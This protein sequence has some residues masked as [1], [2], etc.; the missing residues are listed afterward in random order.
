MAVCEKCGSELKQGAIICRNCG[1]RVSNPVNTGN[2]NNSKPPKSKEVN[3]E[4]TV[5]PESGMSV[6]AF[7][8]MELV[9]LVPCINIIMLIVWAVSKKNV[10]R[11]NYAKAKLLIAIIG[12]IIG[13]IVMVLMGASLFAS[14]GNSINNF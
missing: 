10:T 12:G 6:G 3:V 14:L 2:T 9:M 13:A 1:T 7:I 4:S 11:S 8:I 5:K